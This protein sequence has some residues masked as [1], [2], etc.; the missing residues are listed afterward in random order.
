MHSTSRYRVAVLHI[1]L[2]ARMLCLTAPRVLLLMLAAMAVSHAQR[3]PDVFTLRG[4]SLLPG[5]SQALSPA[6]TATQEAGSARPGVVDLSQAWRMA[7]NHDY[8]YKAAVSERLAA[9]TARQQGRAGLLPQI[10]AGYL[11]GRVSGTITQF[12]FSGR[13]VSSDISY[14]SSHAYVQLRQTL[15]EYGPIGRATGRTPATTD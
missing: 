8:R 3:V 14:D 12:H 2:F 9:Q 15:L 1:W 10:Q 4:S 5:A 7:L 11:R 13:D 6:A